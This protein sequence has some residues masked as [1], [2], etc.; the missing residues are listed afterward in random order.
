LSALFRSISVATDR[1]ADATLLHPV[2]RVAGA[3][4]QL[5]C[6]AFLPSLLHGR[7]VVQ[8]VAEHNIGTPATA[9]V[10]AVAA[11]ILAPLLKVDTAEIGSRTSRRRG[12]GEGNAAQGDVVSVNRSV[13]FVVKLLEYHGC[14]PVARN[15]KT[16]YDHIVLIVLCAVLRPQTG[17]SRS[18]VRR[19]HSGSK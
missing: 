12:A 13:D 18:V 10:S 5:G 8:A 16:N 15:I 4:E 17:T 3:L 11:I 1:H 2:K 9:Q 19:H 7:G 14:N 6:E